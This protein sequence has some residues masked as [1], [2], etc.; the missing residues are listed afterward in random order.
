[1]DIYD[2]AILTQ[3]MITTRGGA[4]ALS[5]GEKMSLKMG[6]LLA[7]ARFKKLKKKPVFADTIIALLL[8]DFDTGI[9]TEN[10][11]ETAEKL[12]PTNLYKS[13]LD[14]YEISQRSEQIFKE[15]MKNFFNFVESMTRDTEDITE[16]AV[17]Y[18]LAEGYVQCNRLEDVVRN[19]DASRGAEMVKQFNQGG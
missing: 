14:V 15:D 3:K 8:N 9:L 16:V 18:K 2:R 13:A 7:E 12:N 5:E 11:K 17:Q 1:M 6:A 4:E 19:M 10:Q